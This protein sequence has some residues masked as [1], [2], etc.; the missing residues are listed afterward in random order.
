MAEGKQVIV[1]TKKRHLILALVT[2]LIGFICVFWIWQSHLNGQR[3]I[4]QREIKLTGHFTA[5]KFENVIQNNIKALENLGAR[6]EVTDG[7]YFDFWEHDAR[8]IIR[9]N[10]SFRFVEWI[11]S[12]MVIRKIEPLEGNEPALN[13][14]IS[15]VRIFGRMNGSN[16]RLIR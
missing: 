9:Q 14:D 2:V 12:N 11:D 8:R 13:L 4:L 5:L 16:T 7:E 1:K 6:I 15:T 10:P 3:E